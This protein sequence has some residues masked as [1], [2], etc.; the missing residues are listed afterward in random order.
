MTCPDC[1]SMTTVTKTDRFVPDAPTRRL[2]TCDCGY[3]G[4][5][6]ENWERRLG[7]GANRPATQEPVRE[8]I[9]RDSDPIRD[10][11]PVS[12]GNPIRVRAKSKRDAET[13]A[14]QVFYGEFPRKK[15]RPRAWRAW[16][17]KGCEAI[18]AEVMAGLRRQLRELQARPA[19]KIPYPASWLNDREWEDPAQTTLLQ[20]VPRHI[21]DRLSKA[22][23]RKL[24]E[25]REAGERRATPDELAALRRGMG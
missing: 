24:A 16:V 20:A 3:R 25:L 12:P 5:S 13:E 4:I 8:N 22:T 9:K 19:E 17:S 23:D 14:F 21:D 1:G 18:A 7:S 15:K 2:R 6:I 10:L 11:N